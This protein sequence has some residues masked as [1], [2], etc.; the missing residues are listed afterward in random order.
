MFSSA[1]IWW[2]QCGQAERGSTIGELL[3]D[4]LGLPF[5]DGDSLHS[6]ANK[7]WMSAGNALTD[8]HRLPWLHEIGERLASGEGSGVVMACSALKRSYRDLLREH[9]PT[10]VIAFASGPLD[11][12]AARLTARRH[13]YMPPSLLLTQFADLEVL[14]GDEPGLT[15]GIEETPAQI[16]DHIIAAI[17]TGASSDDH[18]TR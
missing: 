2:S 14:Q 7:S 5:V 17:Q 13:E 18:H 15:V 10:L 6:E 11:L 16:V 12:I 1:V 3:A 8:A 9:A 4:R